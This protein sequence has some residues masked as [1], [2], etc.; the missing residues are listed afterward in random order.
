MQ[1]EPHRDNHLYTF[2]MALAGALPSLPGSPTGAAAD[3]ARADSS[4]AAR[5]H[6]LSPLSRTCLVDLRAAIAAGNHHALT[7]PVGLA[8]QGALPVGT[9]AGPPGRGNSQYRATGDVIRFVLRQRPVVVTADL[10]AEH[11]DEGCAGAGDG[12]ASDDTGAGRGDT[13]VS[14]RTH[15]ADWTGRSSLGWI[16]SGGVRGYVSEPQ[17]QRDTDAAAAA[18]AAAAAS[19]A[20]AT[21][22]S[23]SVDGAV[24]AGGD[25][26]DDAAADAREAAAL[27]S[28]GVFEQGVS[29][30]ALWHLR[31]LACR[32]GSPACCVNVRVR[33]RARAR[34]DLTSAEVARAAA[35]AA[36]ARR[37]CSRRWC[38]CACTTAISKR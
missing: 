25:G 24:A 31:S 15:A 7:D 20:A 34:R 17:L 28:A 9:L 29:L 18:A 13:G 32:N 5:R 10:P 11:S 21:T 37:S 19:A 35:A 38:G 26:G 1:E 6:P 16:C 12:G 14:L 4:G 33:G 36:P 3:A 2:K 22:T 23:A 30:A 8:L 27:G